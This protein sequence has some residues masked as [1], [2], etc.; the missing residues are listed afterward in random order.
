MDQILI[1][2]LRARCII[3]INP[4]E[5][6]EKQDVIIN[7]VLFADFSRA[8]RNDRIEDAADYRAIKKRV[9][10]AVEA[11]EF[12]LVEALAEAIATICLDDPK[13]RKVR[14]QVEKPSALRFARSV[15]VRILR[16]REG[17]Q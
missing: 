3:G 8:S 6:R 4:D 2:D 1:L 9:L 14:V 17:K 7:L 10:V 12:Q 15:G 11:S 5:R 16:E 13:I